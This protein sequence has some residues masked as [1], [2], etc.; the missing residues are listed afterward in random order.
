MFDFT[1]TPEHDDSP[2]AL[3]SSD[4]LVPTLWSVLVDDPESFNGLDESDVVD[5]LQMSGYTAPLVDHD[6]PAMLDTCRD[7]LFG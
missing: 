4:T 7:Y 5:A 6:F 1:D 3:V 2:D